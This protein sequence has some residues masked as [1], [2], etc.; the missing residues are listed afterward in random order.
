[1]TIQIDGDSKESQGRNHERAD[2]GDDR[3]P[4]EM[5]RIRVLVV[6]DYPAVR[7]GLR[8]ILE[9]DRDIDVVGEAVDGEEAL[10]KAAHLCPDVVTMDLKMPGMDGIAATRTLKQRMPQVNVLA[11]TMCDGEVIERVMRAGAS[12]CVVKNGDC[13]QIIEAVHDVYAG[14]HPMSGFDFDGLPDELRGA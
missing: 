11:L 1:M 13:G 14:H 3:K 7:V 4:Q 6:D 5:S 10:S 8:R 12:G 9:L 2:A